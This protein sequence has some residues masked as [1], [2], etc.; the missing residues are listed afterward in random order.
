MKILAQDLKKGELKLKAETLDDLWELS[1]VIQPGDLMKKHTYRKVKIDFGDRTEADKRSMV[2]V[3]EVDSVEF[4]EF[5]TSL[6]VGGVVQEGPEG[7][8]GHHTFSIQPGDS[9]LLKKERWPRVDLQRLKSSKETP[10]VVM[11][12]ADREQATFATLRPDGFRVEFVLNSRLPRKGDD[13]YEEVLESYFR[14]VADKL[15]SF[16][17]AKVVGG[18]G[19]VREH[20]ANLVEGASIVPASSATESG[21]REMVESDE[22]ERIVGESRAREE[23]KA[24]NELLKRI[25]RDG[26]CAYGFNEVG[27][28]AGMGAVELVMVSEETILERR[29]SGGY[30]GLDRLLV[31]VEN[32]GGEVMLVGSE[33]EHGEKLLSL[34]GVAALLRYKV[35]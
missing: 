33:S 10:K 19:F 23:A 35:K 13:S 31:Q 1:H 12:A 28:A 32:Q 16:E 29:R 21:I 22:L 4:H 14:E 30:E 11:C 18:P 6:R 24:V 20:I 15:A 25:A 3:V 9:F 34:G 27:E 8:T 26:P 17:G 5:E 7:V 2:L